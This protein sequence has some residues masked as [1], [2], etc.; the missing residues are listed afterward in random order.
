MFAALGLWIMVLVLEA[1]AKSVV[2][3]VSYDYDEEIIK[4]A[5]LRRKQ[6]QGKKMSKGRF[7]SFFGGR[8]R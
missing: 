8:N 6:E 4:P 1:L 7:S 2:D 3:P 5:Y